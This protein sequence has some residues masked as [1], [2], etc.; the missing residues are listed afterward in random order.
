M[1]KNLNVFT[2]LVIAALLSS[3]SFGAPDIRETRRFKALDHDGYR[4]VPHSSA[5]GGAIEVTRN[6]GAKGGAAG[7][8]RDVQTA[9]EITSNAI[10]VADA[11][12]VPTTRG[13]QVF[14]A[15][16][17]DEPRSLRLV[18]PPDLLDVCQCVAVS[19]NVLSARFSDGVAMRYSL[20]DIYAPVP[21]SGAASNEVLPSV[22]AES[23]GFVF[24][25]GTDGRITVSRR[26]GD[27]LTVVSSFTLPSGVALAAV[28]TNGVGYFAC[29][30]L[31]LAVVRTN[32]P[33]VFAARGEGERQASA[34]AIAISTDG[35]RLFAAVADF[36][37][38]V[39][40]YDVTDA[41]APTLHGTVSRDSYGD[42]ILPQA[43]SV[44]GFPGGFLV[45]DFDRGEV[46]IGIDFQPGRKSAI[47]NADK[48]DKA[49]TSK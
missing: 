33:P 46:P 2:F 31:P 37:E 35:E 12:Y 16:Q 24:S 49:T 19:S 4:Y 8:V 42:K 43:Y 13:I 5:L 38:G 9:G 30:D 3:A 36:G 20:A 32:A 39:R 1:I 47:I 15:T 6:A 44:E 17:P 41:A 14:D 11:I 45:R 34:C 40:I 29:G 18:P 25:S 22:S 26:D 48:Q 7:F 27:A 21:M 10:M 28:A 23:D